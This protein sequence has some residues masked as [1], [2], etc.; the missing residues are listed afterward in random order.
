[1]KFAYRKAFRKNKPENRK[2]IQTIEDLR[3]AIETAL[4][5]VGGKPRSVNGGSHTEL[6]FKVYQPKPHGCGFY[7]CYE[8][9]RME[10]APTGHCE[11]PAPSSKVRLVRSSE[12]WKD[13]CN[14]GAAK[15]N[16]A[17][18]AQTNKEIQWICK[19]RDITLGWTETFRHCEVAIILGE[20]WFNKRLEKLVGKAITLAEVD[21]AVT[22]LAA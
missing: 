6:K 12:V 14:L 8:E 19:D 10:M 22:K 3:R 20:S 4:A 17:Q 18:T 13:Y 2:M 1:M 5:Q 7:L 16:L 11:V 21:D 9:L 15:P